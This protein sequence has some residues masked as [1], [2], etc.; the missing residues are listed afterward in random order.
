MNTILFP[1]NLAK[2][3]LKRRIAEPNADLI[4]VALTP[5]P[6][7]ARYKILCLRLGVPP[8][9]G[10]TYEKQGSD[11]GVGFLTSGFRDSDR[12]SPH[13][14]GFAI[15]MAVGDLDAQIRAGR[16]GL[17]LFDRIGLYPEN[18]FVHLDLAPPE[19]IEK[20]NGKHFWVKN[21]RKLR[22]SNGREYVGF[23][24][25]ELAVQFARDHF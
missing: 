3:G 17:D 15:D 20:F 22:E 12:N 24:N 9:T 21:K 13:E 6:V 16:L 7:L 19:W 1:A 8:F 11:F 4:T 18:G 23:D 25:F 14:Y 2:L 5:Y 10:G